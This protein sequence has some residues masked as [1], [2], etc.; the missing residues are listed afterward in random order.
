MAKL[1]ISCSHDEELLEIKLQIENILFFREA[2]VKRMN[3]LHIHVDPKKLVKGQILPRKLTTAE[4]N[5]MQID[6]ILKLLEQFKKNVESN[7]TPYNVQTFVLL[8]GKA[9]EHFSS[10]DD[11]QHLYY[12]E[13]M[14]NAL[15]RQG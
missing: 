7:N 10:N 5:R 13:L 6:E 11:D 4:I 9:V 3:G 2:L 15:A 8:C 12:L 14:K 1:Y